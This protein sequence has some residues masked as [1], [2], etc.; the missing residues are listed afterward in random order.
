MQF[1][2]LKIINVCKTKTSQF[3]AKLDKFFLPP[4]ANIAFAYG[5]ASGLKNKNGDNFNELLNKPMTFGWSIWARNPI[6]EAE[7]RQNWEAAEERK[8]YGLYLESLE[9][10]RKDPTN[11]KCRELETKADGMVQRAKYS[12]VT[13]EAIGIYADVARIYKEKGLIAEHNRLMKKAKDTK[14]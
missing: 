7:V 1:R 9:A 8:R 14:V 3:F 5:G 6:Q 11:T 13:M 10:A 4:E 2:N 12:F